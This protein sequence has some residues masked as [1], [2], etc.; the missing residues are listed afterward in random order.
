MKVSK[1]YFIWT[2]I[3]SVIALAI[4]VFIV[5]HSCLDATASTEAS[6]GVVEITEEVINTVA[7]GTITIDNHDSFVSFIR[8]AFGHFGLFL[9]SGFFTS[10]ALFLIINPFNDKKYYRIILIA[11]SSGLLLALLTETIQLYVPGRSGELTDVLIDFGGYL[12][13]F[14]AIFLILFLIIR[15][16]NKQINNV[17]KEN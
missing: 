16:I 5:V 3:F 15:H 1:K 7:P 13:G 10:L 12:L 11:L 6:H 17:S 9:L 2:L 14:S 8:K 4:N